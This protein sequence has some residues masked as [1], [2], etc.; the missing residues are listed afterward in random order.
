MFGQLIEVFQKDAAARLAAL[1]QAAERG[2]AASLRGEAH[3]L[4]GASLNLG[5]RRMGEICRQLQALGEAG[6]VEG[7]VELVEELEREFDRV[8]RELAVD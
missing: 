7:A 1:R 5:A 6:T 8:K 3:T 4:K 2:D